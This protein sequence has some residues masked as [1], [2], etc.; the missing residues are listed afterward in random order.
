M[1]GLI[2]KERKEILKQWILDH[3]ELISCIVG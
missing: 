1:S 3:L 2:F